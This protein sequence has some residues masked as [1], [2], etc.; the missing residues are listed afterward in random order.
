[1]PLEEADKR[2]KPPQQNSAEEV[3]VDQCKIQII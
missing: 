2:R 1:M 3:Y